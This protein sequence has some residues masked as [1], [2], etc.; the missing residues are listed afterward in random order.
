M[1]Q[2]SVSMD[3]HLQSHALLWAL[4]ACCTV[5]SVQQFL[6]PAVL[7]LGSSCTHWVSL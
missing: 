7:C 2:N 6:H 5:L 1:T 4:L 3:M